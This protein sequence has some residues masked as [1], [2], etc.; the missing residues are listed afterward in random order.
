MKISNA[1]LQWF[2]RRRPGQ[3]QVR[4]LSLLPR[5]KSSAKCR[6]PMPVISHQDVVYI[7]N[8]GTAPAIAAIRKT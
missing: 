1:S 8:A 7:D 6:R 3:R 4:F 2:V 5:E